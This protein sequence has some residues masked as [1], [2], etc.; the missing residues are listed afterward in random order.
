MSFLIAL[1]RSLQWIWPFISEIF[2][3]SKPLKQIIKENK[4][5]FALMVLLFLSLLLNYS[6]MTTIHKIVNGKPQE[7]SQEVKKDPK[8]V[9]DPNDVDGD[10]SSVKDRL[11]HIY[12]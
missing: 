12:E 6:S 7:T 9:K 4:F 5:V 8:V 11:N 3:E 10:L 2:F 1:G